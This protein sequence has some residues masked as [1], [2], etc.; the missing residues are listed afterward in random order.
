MSVR[1]LMA[2]AVGLIGVVAFGLTISDESSSAPARQG[3]CAR[4]AAPGGDDANLGTKR[5]P[6]ATAQRLAASLR[7]GQTGCLRAGTYESTSPTTYVLNVLHGGTRDAPITIR[8]V[9]G[10]RARLVGIVV[11]PEGSNNV[12]LDELSIEGTGAH[13]TVKVHASDVVVEDSDITNASRG[14]SCVILGDNVGSGQAVRPVL[15]RNRIH[16]CGS[17][18]VDYNHHHGI[19]ASN[20]VDGRI[21]GNVIWSV[22]AK[23]IQLYP[24]A[25]RMLVAHNIVDGGPP[26]I[27]GSIII[28]G[29]TELASNDN[30]VE[31][32]VI[33]YARTYNVE[34]WWESEVG[35][36]NV[37]RNNCLWRG[38]KGEIARQVGFT[39]AANIVA[40]PQFRDRR[41]RD[42][43]LG[44]SSKCRLVLR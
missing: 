40:D 22:A 20:A 34:S 33:A 11:V 31:R 14:S 2:S 27:R 23:A 24:N 6:F 3:V 44:S 5:R 12:V 13:N 26:A 42:Y 4:F 37:V 9:P 19:Y 25:Q 41:N 8:S 1:A 36:G 21:V 38:T 15:R 29:N 35:S 7:P 39:A 30:V 32:N 16:D 10:E 43:R 18:V 17:N 28:G